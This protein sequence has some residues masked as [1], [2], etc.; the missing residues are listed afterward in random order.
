[1]SKVV[2]EDD[3]PREVPA[4]PDAVQK[5]ADE[6]LSA[7]RLIAR[8][9]TPYFRAM[10][11]ALV[12][13]IAPGL[14]TVG[15]TDNGIFLYDPLAV[16]KWT[17]KQCAGAVIHEVLHLQNRHG[18]RRGERDPMEWNLAGDRAINPGIFEMGLELPFKVAMP[19]DIG[20]KDGLTADEYYREAQKQG[21][22]GNGPPTLGAGQ[23]GGCAGHKNEDEP[24]GGDPNKGG[25]A[26][27]RSEA[28]MERAA[29]QVAEEMSDVANGRQPG[30]LPASWARMAS[31]ILE[32]PKIPWRQRLAYAARRACA[33]K[34][35]QVLHRYDAP[36]RRQAGIGYGEGKAILP[37]LRAPIPDVAIAIDTSGSM[38][39]AQLTEG[40][41]ESKGILEAVGADVTVC[42]CD[43]EVHAFD[44]AAKIETIVRMLKGGGGTDFNPVFRAFEK[45]RK[46]PDVLVFITDGFGP[47][48]TKEPSWCK[49]IWLLVGKGSVRPVDWGEA[50]HIDDVDE[51]AA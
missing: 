24:E 27:G 12:P 16:A 8:K 32:P 7:G 15:V 49:T 19:K 29:R 30:K 6:N 47:A 37:R 1:M 33:Y 23:C 45:Q 20:M 43:A 5:K 44:K 34:T 48:P 17:A 3:A 41:R 18:K 50:I 38:S 21:G 40:L 11:L 25:D 22:K 51:K 46:R 4:V 28:Q 13:R 42:V 10:L 2:K 14:G 36:S 26:D 31:D 35:G 39:K 9:V